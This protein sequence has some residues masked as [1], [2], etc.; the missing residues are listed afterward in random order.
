M[1]KYVSVSV[2]ITTISNAKWKDTMFP[3]VK[4]S[5][6]Q[7]K[8]PSRCTPSTPSS[9]STRDR[10]GSVTRNCAGPVYGFWRNF[11]LL[12]L[13]WILLKLWRPR[14][15]G[16][17]LI[18]I[19]KRKESALW[20]PRA[21]IRWPCKKDGALPSPLQAQ[22]MKRETLMRGTPQS[23]ARH[24]DYRLSLR[25]QTPNWPRTGRNNQNL[26]RREREGFCSQKRRRLF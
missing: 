20:T 18:W 21:R 25:I 10:V 17:G 6:S 11:Y 24:N 23:Q 14:G 7:Y 19:W 26:A 1:F 3:Y 9:F 8:N 22:T 12:S 5:R 13:G 16:K 2:F 4:S 15:K